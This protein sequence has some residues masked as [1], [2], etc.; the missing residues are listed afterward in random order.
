MW[1]QPHNFDKRRDNLKTRVKMIKDIR[2]WFESQEF[3]EVQTP[4]LQLMPSP[5]THIH[6]FETVQW[7]RNLKPL[8]TRGLHTSPEIAMK[9]LLTAG[10]E[11]IYQICPVFR[12]G[13]EGRL[14]SPE[15]TMLEWYRVGEDYTSM[16]GDCESLIKSLNISINGCD[17]NTTW[18][19]LTVP[20]AFQE[21]AQIDIHGDLK[22]QAEEKGIRVTNTDTWEDI[23][24]AV[25]AE[26]IEPYLGKEKPTFLYDYPVSMAALAKKAKDER[27]AERFELYINGVELANA[28]SELT[29]PVEQKTRLEADLKAKKDIYGIDAQIDEEFIAA[30]EYG[31]PESAGCALG[32][33]RLMMLACDADDI[34]DVLWTEKP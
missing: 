4:I 26:K 28:F 25:M 21:Y 12:N 34:E 33:D 3:D 31:M 5:D 14:H 9:K 29:D 10:M 16:M 27:V 32:F 20:H 23:F 6:A 2:A 19:R 13:E 15:F 18:Q 8:G 22:Q 1:W 24:H 7:G 30:L 11:K 17:V